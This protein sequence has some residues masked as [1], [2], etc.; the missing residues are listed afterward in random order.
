MMLFTLTSSFAAGTES[1]YLYGRWLLTATDDQQEAGLAEIIN[2]E[3]I[4]KPG[5]E[6]IVKYNGKSSVEG[7]DDLT[8]T[9]EADFNASPKTLDIHARNK[10]TGEISTLAMIFEI[11]DQD[12]IKVGADRHSPDKRPVSFDDKENTDTKIFVRQKGD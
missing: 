11:T 4:F 8:I 3:F 9:Y 7:R 5:S 10:K 1:D 12:H 6:C 2:L